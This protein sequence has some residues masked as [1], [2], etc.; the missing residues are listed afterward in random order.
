[1]H[2]IRVYNSECYIRIYFKYFDQVNFDNCTDIKGKHCME[3]EYYA[4]LK[5]AGFIRTKH[6]K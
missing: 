4:G 3:I 6:C 1:M 5:T 2:F